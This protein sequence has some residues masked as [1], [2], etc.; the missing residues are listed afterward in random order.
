MP[1]KL[2][3]KIHEIKKTKCLIKEVVVTVVHSSNCSIP[4]KYNRFTF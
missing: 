3:I 1:H 2:K 4:F